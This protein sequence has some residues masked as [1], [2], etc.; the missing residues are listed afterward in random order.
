MGPALALTGWVGGSLSA[1][2]VG[3]G[4]VLLGVGVDY[5]L[6]LYF[7]LR[8]ADQSAA[9]TVARLAGPLLGAGLTTVGAFA[10]QL[11]SSLP[12]QRQL[13]LFA[14]VGVLLAL[15]LA[16]LVLPHFL[17]S[18]SPMPAGPAAAFCLGSRPGF[19]GRTGGPD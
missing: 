10:V 3:F 7:A 18:G 14:G 13:A 19:A 5:G 1:I 8:A 17:G 15:L 12:G 2:T 11:F 6:H 4:A 9:K 16:L